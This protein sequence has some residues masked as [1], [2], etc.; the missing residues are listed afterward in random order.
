MTAATRFPRTA[1]SR[2]ASLLGTAL[3]ALVLCAAAGPMAQ[4][5][6]PEK[7]I[8]MIVAYGAGGSTDVTARMLAP[9]IERYLRGARI[10]ILNRP[11]AGGE[12]GFAAI[13]AE[14]KQL[15]GEFRSL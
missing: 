15:D 13:A 11:G 7:A 5:A 14:L 3:A 6:Y 8:T 2:A 9:Y 4:A 12:I 10:V 1:G